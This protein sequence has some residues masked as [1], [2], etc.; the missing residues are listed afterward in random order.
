MKGA[1]SLL[2]KSEDTPEQLRKK[3]TSPGGT[4]EA[5]LKSLEESGYKGIVGK[6]LQQA[7]NR[8]RELSA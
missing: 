3:V 5:A 1:A 4:T 6:A 2:E 8:S 7:A